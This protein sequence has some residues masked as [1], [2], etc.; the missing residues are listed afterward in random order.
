MPLVVV[1]AQQA[2][3]NEENYLPPGNEAEQMIAEIWQQALGVTKVGTKDNFFDIGGHS[4]L[5]VPVMQ[6]LQKKTEKQIQM[7]DLFRYTTIAALAK[8]I[9]SGDGNSSIVE[10]GQSRAAQRKAHMGKRR[11]QR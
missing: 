5:V 7:T 9:S 3:T 11:R 6:E 10:A 4:L 1:P 8:F 2:V